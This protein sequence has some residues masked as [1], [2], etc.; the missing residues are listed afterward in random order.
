MNSNDI[1]NQVERLNDLLAAS[2]HWE[3]VFN[4]ALEYILYLMKRPSGMLLVQRPGESSPAAVF[5]CNVPEWW[6]EAHSTVLRQSFDK[7]RMPQDGSERIGM[8]PNAEAEQTTAASLIRQVVRQ[9]LKGG[10]TPGG[11]SPWYR[12]QSGGVAPLNAAADLAAAIPLIYD[13]QTQGVLLIQGEALSPDEKECVT[14]LGRAL[15]QAIYARHIHDHLRGQQDELKLLKVMTGILNS[16]SS[17]DMLQTQIIQKM[18][19]A[20][21]AETGCLMLRDKENRQMIVKQTPGE[22]QDWVYQVSTK[23]ERGIVAECMR[24]AQPILSPDVQRDVRFDPALDGMEHLQVRSMLCV[25]ILTHHGDA[26]AGAGGAAGASGSEVRGAVAVYN[27]R[28]GTF[29][30]YD[31]N[32]VLA[33]TDLMAYVIYDVD[34][35]RQLHVASAE[36]EVNR[37]RLVH[38]RNMLLALFDNIPLSF[39]IVDKNYN[40]KAI[41]SARARRT[42]LQPSQLVGNRCHQAL[43]GRGEPCAECQ[44]SVTLAHGQTT[45]RVARVWQNTSELQEWEIASYPIWN[46]AGQVAQVIL[47]EQD[48]TEKRRLENQLIQSEKLAVVGQLAAGVAHEINNPLT[49]VI[50]NAQIAQ[51]ALKNDPWLSEIVELIV[52]AGNRAAQ[53]VRNLLDLARKDHYDF[54]PLD[55]NETIEKAVALIAHE[56]TSNSIELT[57]SAARGLPPVKISAEHIY[58][59]WTNLILNAV[60][61][62]K[63]RP[64]KKIHI[65]TACKSEGGEETL[66]VTIA[67]NGVGIAADKLT[68]IFDPFY[69]TKEVGHG[70]GLGLT[71]CQRIIQQHGG[72][73]DV[74]SEV[75][76]GTEFR[77]YFP[78]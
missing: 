34:L 53:V 5:E 77:V 54:L 64:Q 41:N 29:N 40:L 61:A 43:F 55:V 65:Q 13:E 56:L 17:P 63:N 60:D 68:H 71:L 11:S 62:L 8:D 67:D 75:N 23:A 48:V 72:H 36:L 19:A 14:H 49:A 39:Y 70:T 18:S 50:A 6:R 31:V 66:V 38:S 27:K 21:N 46:E 52:I 10:E 12:S 15:G 7:L 20:V 44:V 4:S 58:G 76:R 30:P 37:W 22:N 69:T 3:V 24:S 42:G 26:A 73:I 32:L 78:I 47:S 45:Q 51:R 2:E 16:N 1:L 9:V 33:F 35:V 57:F 74:V 25:P 28:S 59:V